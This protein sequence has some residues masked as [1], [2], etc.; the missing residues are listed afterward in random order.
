MNSSNRPAIRVVTAN[1]AVKQMRN[2]LGDH[3]GTWYN[4]VI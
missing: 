2:R 1:Q 4:V 3:V